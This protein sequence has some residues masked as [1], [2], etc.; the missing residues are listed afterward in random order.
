MDGLK[1]TFPEG[2]EYRIAYDPTVFVRESIKAVVKTLLEATLFVALVVM[3][4]LQT[5]R[6]SIIPLVAVPVS[7]V[8]T[9]AVMLAFGF[10]LNTL[11]LFGLVLA[12]GIVVDDAIVVVENVERHIALGEPPMQA[13]RLAMAEVSGPIIAIAL[14]LCAVF[15]PTAF[16][17]G[18][19]GQFYR[20]FAL[21]IAISTVISAIN[22]LTLSPAL[23][24]RLLKAHGEKPDWLQ[25]GANRLFGPFFRGFNRFFD[26]TSHAY[27]R[28][29]A[30]TLR[31]AAV[32]GVVYVGLL[33]LTSLG[34]SRIPQGFIPT[35]DKG[36]LVA[37]AQL[38]DASSL[39]RTEAVIRR[40]ADLAMEHPAVESTIAFPGLSVNGFVNASNAGIVFVMLKPAHE[41]NTPELQAGAVVGG[42]NASFAAVQEAYVAIFPP[43][44]VQGMGSVGGFKLYVE[45]R[46]S[47]GFE[48]L[49]AQTQA[50][51]QK[52]SA[53]P[54][55][56]GLFSSFQVNVPQIDADVDRARVKTYGV[57]L[58]DVFDTLQV[59]LGSLYVN[60]FNRFGR[61]YQVNVQAESSFRLQP[62]QI[63]RLETRNAA[64][65]MVP[66]GSL[67]TV[68]R[69]YG[70]DQVMHYNG[71]P[72]A[73]I[74]GG[75]SPG[76]SSGDAQ[77]AIAGVLDAQ[78]PATMTFEWTELAYQ[79]LLSGN[80]MLLIFPL[81][82]LLVYIV[83][84]ALY[85]SWSLPL[86]VILI[87]PM[88]LLP[89]LLGVWLTG[90]DS[91]VFTQVSFLVLAG[92]ACKNA[93]LIVEFARQR[94]A[95]GDTPLEAILE[96]CRV[97]LRPVVMTSIAFIM[98]VV[99]LV[100]STGA[101]FE[102]RQAMGIAVFSG[103]LGV[104]F[105]GLFFIPV[106]YNLIGSLTRWRTWFAAGRVVLP[107]LVVALLTGCASR[108]PYVQPQVEP[109]AMRHAAALVTQEPFD[110]R[111][112][113]QFG[114]PVLDDIVGRAL[115]SNH[116]VRGA[117]AR[118]DQARAIL[119]DVE[120]DRFP[121]VPVGA[122]IDR[123]EQ[124]VPGFS[125]SPR[126]ITTYRTGFDAFWEIDLFGR[127][128]SQVRAVSATAERFEA[129][130]DDIRV[131]VA[132]EV[133]RNYFELRGLQQQMVVAERSL[134]NQRETLR[135]TQVRRDAGIG[136]EQD[137]ASAAARVAAI[138]ASLPPIR[139]A[140]LQREHRMAVLTGA[141]PGDLR[142]D[143]TPRAYP[144]LTTALAIGD[145][146]SL[147]R[148]RPD[149]RAAERELAAA[150][151]REGVAVADLFPRVT[152][153]GFLGFLAGRG[154][155]FSTSD[156]RAWAV[157]PALSW[158]A[159]DL[160]SARARLRGAEAV[161]VETLAGFEQVVLRALEETENALVTYR[162]EQERLVKLTEQASE[163]TRA[164]SIARVRYR[165]GAAD[166]LALLDAERTQLQAED[167]V[168]RAEA[169][170]FTSV[171]GLYKALGGIPAPDTP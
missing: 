38:P 16:I 18:L 9:F 87:V 19:T 96:A 33:G 80:T 41:R 77:A 101:G 144:P 61:T 58:T 72:A 25:R 121:R 88:T 86:S 81:C 108:R 160:G 79:Q 62:E 14:V 5:W 29:V 53:S 145:P 171:I 113:Q 125:D 73:E 152:I 110:L 159:F 70:P 44:P 4:F 148:R 97:R 83:L 49:Y 36:Y 117:L 147:L 167:E 52:G 118:V 37:F 161:T 75:P 91:N 119:D 7:L 82:V 150:T 102:I 55:L 3:L 136:E 141:R 6:A 45:D 154:G 104:T 163:S 24:S 90:G 128:R 64:G 134:T 143:L 142:A 169:G 67:V 40:M 166:F 39:D 15:I 156:S 99:P 2:V 35:Q 131:S 105:F 28:G 30:R 21:T 63:R 10:S 51:L 135:L 103:M 54:E 138:E 123:R 124:A 8:G 126:T 23:A 27:S 13:T 115:A 32:A 57:A 170:V 151:A 48:E 94:E 129:E 107:L 116:D 153:T 112:W 12:I 84:A 92:L 158:A 78:L 146:E 132:A 66:L 162:E 74:N 93:I 47:A 109:A 111:W 60:D 114:D 65:A 46:G 95:A 11:S 20:Q 56:A 157:T 69:S 168:A 127:V 85:E 71:F 50:A 89:A 98:G 164:A 106:F 140:I 130:L 26:R 122:S 1:A 133:A 155:L 31:L 100:F 42:L 120:R 22:S 34:L 59:Y 137:V 139:G 76:Y 149:V 68:K 43:P 165:E 17:S